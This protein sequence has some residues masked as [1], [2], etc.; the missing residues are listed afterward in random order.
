[1]VKDFRLRQDLRHFLQQCHC[2]AGGLTRQTLL[3]RTHW[4]SPS[5]AP[6]LGLRMAMELRALLLLLLCF[7]GKRR[8]GHA[9]GFPH[10]QGESDTLPHLLLP[11]ELQG[12][13]ESN[14]SRTLS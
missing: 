1:M 3:N 6:S 2:D 7:P 4:A 14:T 10:T 9:S 8:A 12:G 13:G 11:G 5:N